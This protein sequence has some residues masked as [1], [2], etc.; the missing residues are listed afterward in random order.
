MKILMSGSG[1]GGHIYPCISLYKYLK[2]DYQIIVL[3]FKEIDK[4]IYDKN[5]IKYIYIDDKL[6][7]IKKLRLINK[8]YKNNDIKKTITFGNKNS[9]YV[10]MVS[11]KNNVNYYI[12]EQNS[13]IGKANK[14]SYIFTKYIFTNFKLNL[15]KEVNV[16]NPN[17]FINN[18]KKNNLFNNNKITI[19]ITLGSLG[20][21]S[22][23][24]KIINF[25]KN[26][27][28]YNI[29]Y[30]TGNNV[31]TKLSNNANLKIYNFYNPLKDLI[32]SSDLIISRAGASTLAEI[33]ALNKPSIIIPSPYVANNHQYKNAKLL[34]DQKCCYMI[35]E[36]ELNISVL[37][38]KINNLLLN[39]QTYKTMKENLSK[40]YLGNN[41]KLI[42][43][44]IFD[45]NL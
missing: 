26:N 13:I 31:K 33:I 15:K 4:K 23:N 42:K 17:A 28:R 6:P 30:V 14:L 22:V 27:K 34:Y 43:E 25:I 2:D 44:K 8:V 39:Q 3:T 9:F 19:L 45:D 11:L 37:E 24:K 41:F 16:G 35:L 32:A 21:D 1:S 20:S 18:Y 36:N 40:I 10:N 7:L 12:F 29:I 38:S 5:N